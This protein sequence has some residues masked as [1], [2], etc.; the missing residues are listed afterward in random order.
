[1]NA[2]S[3]NNNGATSGKT[4]ATGAGAGIAFFLV[5]FAFFLPM[6]G[7]ATARQMP[8]KATMM[9]HCQSGK[10]EPEDPDCSDP[11]L[12]VEPEESLFMT[13]VRSDSEAKEFKEVPL[14]SLDPEEESH[15]VTVVVVTWKVAIT[16]SAV[17]DCA[18]AKAVNATNV[19]M[20]MAMQ[21]IRCKRC[22]S[23]W[24]CD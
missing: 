18:M 1:M 17:A 3:G 14:E 16:V 15:G 13:P 4:S 10:K 9:S 7:T 8:N 23:T 11:E 2:T 21:R 12:A 22:Q 24:S 20:A 6:S 5:F 19:L